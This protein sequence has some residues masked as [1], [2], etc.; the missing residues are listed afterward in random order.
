MLAINCRSTFAIVS[1]VKASSTTA[2]SLVTMTPL[3][4][5]PFVYI[6]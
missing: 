2:P 4:L 5:A 3:I 6:K 1:L